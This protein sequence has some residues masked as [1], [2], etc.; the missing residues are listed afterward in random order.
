MQ[1]YTHTPVKIKTQKHED[2]LHCNED[3]AKLEQK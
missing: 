1:N 3:K 2:Y